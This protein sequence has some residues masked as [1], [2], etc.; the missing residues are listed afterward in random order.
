MVAR[1]AATHILFGWNDV[2]RVAGAK[3][4]RLSRGECWRDWQLY[5]SKNGS[6]ESVTAHQCTTTADCSSY[7]SSILGLWESDW[8]MNNS[9]SQSRLGQL[10]GADAVAFGS[11]IVHSRGL[12]RIP[13][14][15]SSRWMKPCI[16]IATL[17]SAVLASVDFA[18][19]RFKSVRL[20]LV[21]LVLSC[22][23][24]NS[25]AKGYTS[26]TALQS[27]CPVLVP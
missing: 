6:T 11:C 4:W 20:Q 14:S 18:W 24:Y 16:L 10:S 12:W 25:F 21:S 17:K 15:T 19:F 5:S 3:H 26:W 13:K 1:R 8:L 23:K 27:P 7:P 9:A 22:A 2:W